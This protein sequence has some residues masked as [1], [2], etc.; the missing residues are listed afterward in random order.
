MLV[1]DRKLITTSSY[2]KEKIVLIRCSCEN[3]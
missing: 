1:L 2:N 3:I